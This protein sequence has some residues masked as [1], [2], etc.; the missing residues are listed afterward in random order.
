MSLTVNHGNENSK[1]GDLTSR[2]RTQ[3]VVMMVMLLAAVLFVWIGAVAEEQSPEDVEKRTVEIKRNDVADIVCFDLCTARRKARDEHFGGNLLDRKDLVQMANTAKG[4]LITKL[5]VDYGDYFEDIFINKAPDGNATGYRNTKGYSP[6]SPEGESMKRLKR[7]LMIKILSMQNE[8]KKNEE[9]VDGCDCANGNKAL[10]ESTENMT[11][12]SKQIDPTYARYVWATGG[13]SASAGHGN[14]YNESY[15][16]FLER[17]AKIVFEAIGIDFEGRNYAMGGTSSGTEISMCWEQIFGNDVDFFSWDFGM[18]DGRD[19]GMRAAHYGY[20]G[21]LSPGRPAFLVLHSGGRA[22]LPRETRVKKLEDLGMAAF[23]EE[24]QGQHEMR[25]AIPESF[26]ISEEEIKNLP[27]YVR[28][29][30][31]DGKLENGDPYCGK[32]KF[33]K[34]TCPIRAKQTSWHPGM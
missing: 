32:E 27:E 21:G 15:T 24:G 13:H 10:V 6:I 5:K 25:E 23:I 4:K 22:A 2:H 16:A 31:C 18:T 33:T 12:E 11:A 20:R 3:A 7:K 17:D 30:K 8:M 34:H 14:L 26:G 1:E 28:N 9:S 19:G 29:F